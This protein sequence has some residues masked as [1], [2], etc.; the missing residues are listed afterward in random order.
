MKPA[1]IAK[2]I[3]PAMA[4]LKRELAMVIAEY[5]TRAVVAEV[6][7]AT[8]DGVRARLTGGG[9]APEPE[10]EVADEKPV[11]KRRR[12][13]A[14]AKAA[15]AV[16]TAPKRSAA[17]N[18]PVAKRAAPATSKGPVCSKCHK[19]GH[20]ARTCG[21]AP[22]AVAADDSDDEGEDAAPPLPTPTARAV[23]PLDDDA[24]EERRLALREAVADREA[25]RE[26]LRLER[27]KRSASYVRR[28]G[29]PRKGEVRPLV[30]PDAPV[31]DGD[32]KR[33]VTDEV[34]EQVPVLK[35]YA[36]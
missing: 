20:N 29:R 8:L 15:P 18:E 12:K 34:L 24:R 9:M 25:R 5:A 31:D 14:R 4:E 36:L 1:D 21:K 7:T 27:D 35:S 33:G 22:A 11:K 19:G 28:P 26:Q 23:V 32:G 2:L 6:R 17:R 13:A 10:Q 16:P 3:D 30:D